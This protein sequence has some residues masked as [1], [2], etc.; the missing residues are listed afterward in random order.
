[1][2]VL[3]RVHQF[4]FYDS[5]MGY[6]AIFQY[7]E[8][9]HS[10][11]NSFVYTLSSVV[12]SVG[13]TLSAAYTLSRPKFVGKKVINFFFVFTMFFNGG[14][15]P[16]FLVMKD[17]GLYNT[18][19]VMIL[20][21]CVSVWNLM[22]ARTYIQTSI[23]QELYEASMLDGA[24]H[25][26]YYFRIVLPLCKTII[27]VLVVYYGVSKWN[28]YFTGLVY[29]RDRTLLPLQ[30]VLREILATLQVDKSGDYMMSM[31]DSASS[32]NEAVRIANV[33][34]Y[35]IIVVATG[36]VVILY[37]FMQKYFEKGVMI[38][39]LKG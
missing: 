17:I 3:Q 31:A 18:P 29:L 16:T 9:L 22:V 38:G 19:W 36:P 5:L 37:A 34:K 35:C 4:A 11:F 2:Y 30:T 8:M 33:A 15:I 25:F 1:V 6:K 23:P 13:I 7:S 14:L 24:N 39:S 26:Q 28:D 27:A 32:M 12:L 10:Y 20:M 21:G